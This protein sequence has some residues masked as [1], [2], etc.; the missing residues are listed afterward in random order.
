MINND[1]S[2]Q[3]P[4]GLTPADVSLN[5]LP[6]V[7]LTDEQFDRAREIAHSR[8]KSYE[9]IDG[10]RI[11]GDQ[12]SFEAHLTGVV[13]E[14]AIAIQTGRCIDESI[15]QYG[16]GGSDFQDSVEIDAKTTTTHVERP[17]L[18]VPV[19]PSPTA[20]LYHL[21]HR[22]DTRTV[23]II[24]F[25]THATVTDRT[26]VREPGDSLNY[27]VPPDELWLPPEIREDLGEDCSNQ[28]P[29]P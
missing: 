29:T 3:K 6:T 20:D 27:F 16:D 2:E 5:L 13:G 21:L 22:I 9:R 12:T 25:A 24:G 10:G 28:F 18:I 15:Y 14:M 4:L 26:P 11:C 8:N 1:P 17:S 19:E 7:E 23:R